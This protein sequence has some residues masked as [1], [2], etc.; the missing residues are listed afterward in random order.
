MDK[1]QYLSFKYFNHKNMLIY[2][3][4]TDVIHSKIR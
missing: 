3:Q 2:E 1:P 4:K